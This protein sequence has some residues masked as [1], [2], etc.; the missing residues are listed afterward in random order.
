[1]LHYRLLC[2]GRRADDPLLHAADDYL[3]RLVPYAKSELV[4]VREG[5][6][7]EERDRLQAHLT[8]RQRRIVLDERGSQPSTIEL[9]NKVAQWQQQSPGPIVFVIGGADGLH[10][11]IKSSAHELWSLSRLTLPHRL[12]QVLLLEQLYRAHTILRGMTYHRV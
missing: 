11:D 6:Q 9:S 8:G 2:V 12:A 1:M 4:R 10:T 5:S 7:G 3:A